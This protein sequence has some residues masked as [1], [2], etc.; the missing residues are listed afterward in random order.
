[1][2]SAVSSRTTTSISVGPFQCKA[3]LDSA[4]DLVFIGVAHYQRY[5]QNGGFSK[6]VKSSTIKNV[7]V[8]N[9]HKVPCHSYFVE[10]L[11]ISTDT[12]PIIV[13]N[14]KFYVV[15]GDWHDVLIGKPVLSMLGILPVDN[16]SK[17]AGA[18][19]DLEGDTWIKTS[20]IAELLN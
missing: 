18:R 9:N 7:I 17:L 2:A 13:Q 11:S 12:L 10:T 4:A 15:Q 6:L 16:L 8:A 19:I 14:V 20:E 3:M 1:V 5:L